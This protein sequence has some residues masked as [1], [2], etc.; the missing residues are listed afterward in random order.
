MEASMYIQS[1]YKYAKGYND[2]PSN[3][4]AGINHAFLRQ[5]RWLSSIA[6]Y[7]VAL[8]IYFLTPLDIS[9]LPLVFVVF[10]T[11][12]LNLALTSHS[13][14]YSLN[15]KSPLILELVFD[16]LAWSTFL[17]FSGGVSNPL[18]SFL[19]TFV[20]IGATILPTHQAWR[21]GLFTV[22]VYV[23]LWVSQQHLFIFQINVAIHQHL[24]GMGLTFICSVLVFTWFI[25]RTTEANRKC[26]VDLNTA[27][28]TALRDKWI[29]SLGS[30]AA[31]TAH[32]LSTPLSTI[33]T[34]VEEMRNSPDP[35]HVSRSDLELMEIQLKV[36]R[37]AL[38]QL[39]QQAGYPSADVAESCTAH[40][41]LLQ[42]GYAWQT[43]HPNAAIDITLDPKLCQLSLVPDISLEQAVSNLVDNAAAVHSEGIKLSAR[44]SG[45]NIEIQITDNGPGIQQITLQHIERGQP[46]KSKHGL[47]LGLALSKSTIERYGG[48][49]QIKNLPQGG[50]EATVF[51]PMNEVRAK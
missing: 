43:L 1:S 25:T 17:Y 41:W 30:L 20:A 12:V 34:L 18:I 2:S 45:N 16:I 3:C 9:V 33:S 10:T 47:G 15:H 26:N 36:C 5:L 46:Q 7:L 14:K 4:A 8:F 35:V 19:L 22:L 49:M 24:L 39:T 51:L 40:E 13:R 38:A 50:T 32:S 27:R 23:L 31:G 48:R 42:L 44:C 6:M 28:Q 29:V 11:A 37:Q 21:L